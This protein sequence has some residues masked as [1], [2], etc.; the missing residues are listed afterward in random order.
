CPYVFTEIPADILGQVY[1]RFLGKVIRLTDGHRAKIEERPEVR[2]SGGVYY[3]PTYIV[4]YIVKATVGLLVKDRAPK[5]VAKLRIIDPACGSGSFLIGAYQFLLDWHREWYASN[6]PEKWAKGKNP[7]VFRGPRNDWQL[8]TSKRKEI[9]LNN[10]FGVD[11]DAQ[12]IEVTK[13]SLL[14]KVLEGETEESIN[15]NLSLFHDR[16]LPDLGKNIRRGNSL[17]GPDYYDNAANA[18]VDSEGDSVAPFD[19]KRAFPE[20]FAAGGFDAVVGN[21]PYLSFGGRQ[22]VELPPGVREYLYARYES[23][24]WPTAHSFF[25]EQSAKHLSKRFLSFIVPDQVGHLDGYRSIREILGNHANVREVRY[26]GESVFRGVTT[27]ALTFVLDK[28]F[29]EHATIIDK[30]ESE[31]KIDLKPGD[32]WGG[33]ASQKLLQKIKKDSFSIKPYIADCG[34]RTTAASEQVVDLKKA[35][36]KFLP[37]LEGKQIGRYRCSPPEIAVRLDSGYDLFKSKD[38]KYTNALYIIRQTAAYPIVA[39]HEHAN[40]F[41]N[42]LHGLYTPDNG[43]DIRY[44]V[45]LLN[46][47]LIRFAYVEMIREAQQKAFPQVKLGALAMLPMRSIDSPATKTQHDRIVEMVEKM[48]GLQKK[49]QTQRNPNSIESVRQQIEMLDDQID[50][51]V[52]GL[53]QLTDSEI[54]E[55]EKVIAGLVPPP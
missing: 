28:E 42:S 27:P 25:M 45:G 49:L 14:L 30:D 44:L 54:A 31:R 2:K 38:E 32:V 18:S 39:P 50:K 10:I 48:L 41:R 19:W 22:S 47:K 17:V 9:L 4:E 8:T 37:A 35:K 12:A 40:Y 52:Y 43:V 20:V 55:V 46:S 53:Y 1:E 15:K 21:P 16:A 6:S 51:A 33:S 23:S 11:L 24:G 29:D 5:D 13:L 26:W 34:I 7:A 36:G 3:T